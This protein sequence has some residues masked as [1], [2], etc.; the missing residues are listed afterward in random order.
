MAHSASVLFLPLYFLHAAFLVRSFAALDW[1]SF[2]ILSF[3]ILYSALLPPFPLVRPPVSPSSSSPLYMT[4]TQSRH[5][6]PATL[7]RMWF[8]PNAAVGA[9]RTLVDAYPMCGLGV[10]TA[11]CTKGGVR[12][13]TLARRP[14]RCA[15]EL[16]SVFG[17][18]LVA[19]ARC[20][21]VRVAVA[22]AVA[23]EPLAW[24]GARAHETRDADAGRPA[25]AVIARHGAVKMLT[26]KNQER[27][28]RQ[29]PGI[30]DGAFVDEK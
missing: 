9:L 15:I 30:P 7:H 17:A 23:V 5:P 8:G 29:I 26:K 11:R 19:R 4:L 21:I 1:L 27:S 24:Q 12:G 13:F 14:R 16:A 22:V 18:Q 6:T 10:Q 2:L 3:L 25:H 20:V 28:P